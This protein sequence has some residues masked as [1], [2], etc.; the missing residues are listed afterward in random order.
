MDPEAFSLNAWSHQGATNV[1]LKH[2]NAARFKTLVNV[3]WRNVAPK[4]LVAEK[5]KA[6]V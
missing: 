6:D 3:A 1:H 5:D 2:V 4:R